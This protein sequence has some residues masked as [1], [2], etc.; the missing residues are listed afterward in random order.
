MCLNVDP[1]CLC[2][3]AIFTVGMGTLVQG[4]FNAVQ[5]ATIQYAP[6]VVVHDGVFLDSSSQSTSVVISFKA[7]DI[8]IP[9]E[10]V[11]F[12]LYGITNSNAPSVAIFPQDKV[13]ACN[14]GA[15]STCKAA[16]TAAFH[17]VQGTAQSGTSYTITAST[18]S[19]LSS[20]KR[21]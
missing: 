7:K 16:G 19:R 17:G 13:N 21:Y 12:P 18:L 6:D 1:L 20:Q 15:G 14:N 10:R 4:Q 5:K 9:S 8:M 3:R 11:S 2:C